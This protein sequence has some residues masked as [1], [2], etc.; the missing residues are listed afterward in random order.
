[1]SDVLTGL[2]KSLAFAAIIVPRRVNLY[3][4]RAS[5]RVATRHAKVRALRVSAAFALLGTPWT[6][7]LKFSRRQPAIRRGPD[8][9]AG[10]S[11][12]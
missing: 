1:M 12:G 10:S 8:A 11:A 6:S 9:L 5:P 2:V 7:I 4:R 3:Y